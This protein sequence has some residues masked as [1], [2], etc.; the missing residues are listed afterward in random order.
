MSF[1]IHSPTH[2]ASLVVRRTFA[3][4]HDKVFRAW[5][6]PEQIV[7]WM[8]PREGV[9]TEFAEFDLKVGGSYRIRYRT[10]TGFVVVGGSFLDQGNATELVLTHE[11]F[12]NQN[13]RERHEHGWTGTLT[14][15]AAFVSQS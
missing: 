9:V 6:D 3:A 10:P 11:H 13:M 15:L 1:A 8:S 14:S 4:R 12:S 7:K 2:P 5:T